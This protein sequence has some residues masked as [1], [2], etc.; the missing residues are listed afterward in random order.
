[1]AGAFA[2]VGGGPPNEVRGVNILVTGGFGFIGANLVP[3][4]MSA[5]A[6]VR[7]FD[8][9]TSGQP[10]NLDS[11]E[12]QLV[13]GDA[14]DT[15]MVSRMVDDVE[16]VIHLAAFGSVVDSIADPGGASTLTCSAR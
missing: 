12:V 16:A 6:Q 7:V 1:M 9:S 3:M 5:G 15:E 11:L 4:L 13:Q 2:Q 14:R 10:A 8:N